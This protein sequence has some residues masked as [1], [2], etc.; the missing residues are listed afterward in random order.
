MAFTAIT[1]LVSGTATGVTAVLAAMAQ[2]GTIMTVVGAVTGNKDLMKI[3]GLMGLVGGI[4][5]LVA[6]AVGGAATAAGADAAV[7]SAGAQQTADIA[8]QTA[9]EATASAVTQS[10]AAGQ[11][12]GI[13]GNGIS[14]TTGINNRSA[15][16]G[17]ATQATANAANQTVA[18][19]GIQ[20]PAAQIDVGDAVGRKITASQTVAT[21]GDATKGGNFFSNTMDFIKNPSNKE[22]VNGGMKLLGGAFQGMNESDQANQRIQFEKDKFNYE[23]GRNSNI[24][25]QNKSRSGILNGG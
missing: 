3:G 16:V 12:L 15:F 22:F 25:Q 11:D 8:A 14:P 1:A 23:V 7:A 2:V 18:T 4:G 13:L 19:P 17:E 24:N 21:P 20:G 6:G 9:T 10:S 5:G